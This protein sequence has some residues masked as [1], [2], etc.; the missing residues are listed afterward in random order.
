L[1]FE[2]K[3]EKNFFL[4]CKAVTGGVSF[5]VR[6]GVWDPGMSP[7]RGSGEGEGGKATHEAPALFEIVRVFWL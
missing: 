7:G 3:Y 2:A 6:Q 4:K 5:L 1:I